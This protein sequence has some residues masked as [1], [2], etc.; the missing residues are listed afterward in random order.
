[1]RNLPPIFGVAVLGGLALFFGSPPELRS[2]GTARERLRLAY[3]PNVTHAPAVVGMERGEFQKAAGASVNIETRVFTDGPTAMEALLA[4]EVD[5]AYVGPGPA[6][7][8]Y[9]KSQGRALRLLAEACSGGAALV[10]RSEA[11]INSL[12]DLDGKRV[13]VPQ[14][15]GTQDISLR[16]FL[17]R[18]G[19]LPRERGGTVQILPIKPADVLSLLA[20]GEVDAAWVPEPW[21]SR[22]IKEAKARLLVDER[23]LW[24]NRQFPT[25]V[26][27]ARKAYLDQHPDLVK[28]IL[29]AHIQ[30]VA[31]IQQNPELAQTTINAELKRLTGKQLAKDVLTQSWERVTFTTEPNKPALEQ[32]ARMAATAGYLKGSLDIAALLDP[33][34]LEAARQQAPTKAASR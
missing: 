8:T 21:T 23:D 20:K 17:S 27:V 10:V 4:G 2:Q 11:G 34:P 13:A 3:F 5:V 19:L 18:E 12:R 1:M 14:L 22:L 26:I 25:T 7:N 16:H 29:K 9:L 31:W 24:P 15:G 33:R 32:F 6:I 28:A 30:T